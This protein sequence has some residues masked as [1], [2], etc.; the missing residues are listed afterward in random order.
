MCF[1]GTCT[2]T[3]YLKEEELMASLAQKCEGEEK[4]RED[5]GS[6]ENIFSGMGSSKYKLASNVLTP[7][8]SKL[9]H[10]EGWTDQ[11]SRRRV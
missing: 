2:N 11:Q 5:G 10:V 8:C 9:V 1:Y 7:I 3:T 6:R 4:R